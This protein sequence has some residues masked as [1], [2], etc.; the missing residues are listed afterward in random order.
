LADGQD[1]PPSKPLAEAFY[2]SENQ[3]KEQ[4]K[5]LEDR[6]EKLETELKQA[7]NAIKEV[8]GRTEDCEIILEDCPKNPRKAISSG[9]AKIPI[10]AL[11]C[12]PTPRK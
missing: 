8:K 2:M 12:E 1:S 3:L 10:V 11:P 4:I 9:P 7:L 5:K 6:V